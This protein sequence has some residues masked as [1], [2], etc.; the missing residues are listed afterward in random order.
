M[1]THPSIRTG[2]FV[3]PGG[4]TVSGELL[5]DGPN[6]SLV[7]HD[8]E[9]IQL[10]EDKFDLCIRGSLHDLSCVTL[11]HSTLIGRRRRNKSHEGPVSHSATLFPNFIAA[12]D[13]FLEPAKSLVRA[14]SFT[15]SEAFALF[16]DLDAFGSLIDASPFIDSI[17]NAEA[18][19][20]GRTIDTGP[21]PQIAYFT[22][23]RVIVEVA[24]VLGRIAASHNPTWPTGGPRGVHIDNEILVTIT[25][26]SPVTFEDAVDHHLLPLIRFLTVAI[27]RTPIVPTFTLEIDGGGNTPEHL[28]I[29]W[30]HHPRRFHERKIS[31]DGPNPYDVPLDPIRRPVEFETLLKSWFARDPE[32]RDARIR[33][34]AAYTQEDFYSPDRLVGA[35]NAFDLLP[36]DAVPKKTELPL[37]VAT[38]KNQCQDIAGK[39]AASE[40]RDSLLNALGR[41]GQST[42]KQKVR[43]R[44][45]IITTATGPGYFAE[46]LFVCDRAV[47]C[48]NHYVHGSP[49]KFDVTSG[50]ILQ[51]LTNTLEFVFCASEFIEMSWDLLRLLKAGNT[52]T[53]PFGTY[54][55]TYNPNLQTLKVGMKS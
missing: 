8:L 10:P 51:F 7:L 53:H 25:P 35:A 15:F 6:S 48:R 44:A 39:L 41:L 26:N 19:P 29:H 24:T 4:K 1:H 16:Y 21:E 20:P 28:E 5:I 38:A 11:I 50:A 2:R 34:D 47:D 52:M 54:A 42:L 27:G 40:M 37:A 22:G 49:I 3:T 45:N 23:R 9:P 17:V 43:H 32:R 33:A 30:S 18:N 14:I 36:D 46:L 12:G 31:G 55:V 13:A